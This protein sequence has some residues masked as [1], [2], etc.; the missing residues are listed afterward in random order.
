MET[1]IQSATDSFT[2]FK[3][4]SAEKRAEYLQRVVSLLTEYKAEF[5][6][7]IVAEAGKPIGYAKAEVDRCI[8]TLETAVREAYSFTGET[9]PI[10]YGAGQGKTAFTKRV[11]IGPIACISPFNFP[12]NLALH[13]IAPA[14]AC[15]CT[16]VLKPAPQSPLS[17]LAFAALCQ[18]AGY[19]AGV[20]NI[21]V[22]DIPEAQT[23]VTDPRMK[24]LSFTGSPQVGWHLKSIAGRKKTV[25]ELGG[26]AAAIID[27]SADLDAAAKSCA[28]GGY[29]YAGQICIST[30]RIFVQS[31]V[32]EKFKGKLIAE[33]RKLQV[34]DPTKINTLVGPIID[35]THVQR[36]H[37]W[38]Q[39]AKEAGAEILV[40]GKIKDEEAN[41]YAPTLLTNTSKDMKVVSEEVFGPVAV[42]EKFEAFQDAIDATNDSVFGLQAGVFTNRLDHMKMAH[43]QLEVGGIM[44]NN[45]AGFRVD[46]MPYGGVKDSGLGR[47][48]IKYAMEDMTE[49]RL[50]VY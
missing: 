50:I 7:L 14:L 24:L 34:G 41:L 32:F 29:L 16:V 39:E 9:V 47:E 15:G 17:C 5:A 2:Y 42:I 46:S 23:L 8:V 22:A 18:E 6:D 12:L 43:E 25:L 4:W 27:D 21:L 20:V 44:M 37:S 49:P 45:V 38:V 3:H 33:I 19:P 30:Q 35:K 26:N 40:G 13:K 48:G 36:I 10:D 11:P 1:A 31:N 28:I